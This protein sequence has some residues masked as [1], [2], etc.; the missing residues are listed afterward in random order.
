MATQR[1][2]QQRGSL[3]NLECP[4]FTSICL[5]GDL[6]PKALS[7]GALTIWRAAFRRETQNQWLLYGDDDRPPSQYLCGFLKVPVGQVCCMA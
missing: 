3:G 1:R 7:A 2:P 5:S 4:Q 6:N